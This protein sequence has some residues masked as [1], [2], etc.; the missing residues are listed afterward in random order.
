M[1][2]HKRII[3]AL[4]SLLAVDSFCQIQIDS[5][6]DPRY[7]VESVLLGKGVIVG[8]IEFRGSPEAIGLYQDTLSHLGIEEGIILTTGNAQ[9][10][11]G[12]NRNP[13][14]GWLS[15]TPGDPDLRRIARGKTFDAAALEFDFIAQTSEL[16][17]NFVFA[18]E[19]YLEYV[20][21][22]FND[23]FGFFLTRNDSLVSNLAVLPGS[24]IPVTVN[25]INDKN[26]KS[27]YID[28]AYSNATEQFIWDVRKRRVKKNKNF[29]KPGQP[30]PFNTQFDGFTKVLTAQATVVPNEIYHIKIVIADVAD[31]ILDS[32][33]FLEGG[34]FQSLAV[35]SVE[36]TATIPVKEKPIET[37][38][39]TIEG[40][41][42]LPPVLTSQ[43][44]VLNVEFEFDSEIVP[45][46][47]MSIIN[48]V[49]EMLSRN[50]GWYVQVI[51]HADSDGLPDYNYQL[52]RRRSASVVHY[53]KRLGVDESRMEI[54]FYGEDRPLQ[55]NETDEGKARNRR[56]EFI[57]KEA[58]PDQI[59]N[60]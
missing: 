6:S 21:S 58:L 3:F 19:E 22:A 29:R 59:N 7:L 34:S 39:I 52:S 51:G 42:G 43:T 31:G 16:K 11:T 17:F 8:N 56:V 38:K 24:T 30:P 47:A 10:S 5:V 40:A 32:G 41:K 4:F 37:P 53:L 60:R 1:G 18:S 23:V 57:L 20:G 28:N 33:V 14:T 46:Q 35:D 12:P 25:S 36:I 2:I 54:L 26:N 9:F 50:P 27:F 44:R 55:A 45:D 15:G 49:Y 13:R 48:N